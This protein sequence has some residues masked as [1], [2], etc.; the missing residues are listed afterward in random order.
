M[1][2]PCVFKFQIFV[3]LKN[4]IYIIQNCNIIFKLI[5]I[6]NFSLLIITETSVI[7]PD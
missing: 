1:Q 2:R 3:M 5:K 4:K 7:S 6:I